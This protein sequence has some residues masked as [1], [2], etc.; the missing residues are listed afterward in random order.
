MDLVRYLNPADYYSPRI[1]KVGKVFEKKYSFKD[2]N[3]LVKIRDV[4]KI[5][6][7]IISISFFFSYEN[8]EKTPNLR[9]KN[10]DILLLIQMEV[11]FT[12]Y[13]SKKFIK[14]IKGYIW[15]DIGT[16]WANKW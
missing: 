14:L 10:V 6:K 3:F 9:V 1:D 12:M 15:G 13:L 11:N 4:Q 8:G 2:R 5:D 16:F 7:K